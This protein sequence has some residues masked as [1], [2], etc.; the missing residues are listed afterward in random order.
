M[1]YFAVLFFN[2]VAF[3]LLFIFIFGRGG[4]INNLNKLDR[5]NQLKELKANTELSLEEMKYRLNYLES[6]KAPD[7]ESLVKHG[8]KTDN[9]VIFRFVENKTDKNNTKRYVI[10]FSYYRIYFSSILIA[11]LIISGNILL[12]INLGKRV[13]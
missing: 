2:L 6:L 7:N 13:A 11:L 4:M 5:I 12:C 10:E 3:Y 8:K 1:K 9:M